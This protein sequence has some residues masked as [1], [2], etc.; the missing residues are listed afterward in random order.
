MR[1][2]ILEQRL[3]PSLA[4]RT[5]SPIAATL[6]TI[7]AGSV[8]F[9][10]LGYEPL[11]TLRVFLID[12]LSNVYGIS[13]VLLKACPLVLIGLGLAIGFRANVWNIGAEGQ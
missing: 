9:Y 6:V 1:R 10:V 8:M 3:R 11:G 2:L 7:L 13:E 4:V 12:P 5:L